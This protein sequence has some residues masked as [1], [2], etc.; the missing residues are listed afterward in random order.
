M[1]STVKH[2]RSSTASKRPTASGLA[3]GQL[4]INTAS[5]TPGLFL[6]NSAGAVVKVGPVHVGASAPNAVPAGSAGN[7]TGELW[8]NNSATIHGLNY[9]TGSA[10]VNLTP[11]GTTTVAGLVELATNAET[12]TGTDTVRAV[13]PSG[14]QS[15]VSDSTSTTS[16]T[17][18]ASSTAVKSAYDVAN[19]AL[20]K[21]GGRI[22]GNLEIGP[23]GSLSFE[24]SSDDSFETTLA[25]VNPTADRTITLPNTTGTVITTG[26]SG[27][28]TSAM[29][30][31]LNIVNADINASAAI[32]LSKLATGAL[33][34]AITVASA[35]IVNG[36]IVNADISASA[37]IAD[38]KLDTIS[39]AGK[40]SGTAITSGDIATSGDLEITSTTPIVR[41][42]ESDGTAT[43][44]QTAIVRNNDQFLLQTRSSTGVLLSNDYLIPADASGATE[45][46]WRIANTE[47]ARLDS[48][49]LTVVNDLT[50]SDKIIHAG[51]T[52][53][54]IRFPAADTVAVET[55]G[56]ERLRIKSDGE[57]YFQANNTTSAVTINQTGTG[58][59]LVVE[60]STNPDATPFVIDETGRT[61]Q[62]H[63]VALSLNGTGGTPTCQLNT[64]ASTLFAAACYS[65]VNWGDTPASPGIFLA[66][67]RAGAVG[68]YTIVPNNQNLGEIRFAGAD[69]SQFQN[70]AAIGVQVDGTPSDGIV[71]GRVV[72]E[73]AN[74]SGTLTEAMRI[75][76]TGAVLVGAT[77]A[78]TDVADG[79]IALQNRLVMNASASNYGQFQ[80]I[81]DVGT[82]ITATTGTIVFKFKSSAPTSHRSAFVK[83]NLA[84][85]ANNSTPSNSPACEYAFQLHQTSGGIC[86]ING[87]TTIFEYTFVRATHF[88][89]ADLGSGECTVTLTN[90]VAVS[91]IPAYMV[92]INTQAGTFGLDAVTIT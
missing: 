89:F 19:A 34:T 33:P 64:P 82:N 38:T 75:T 15:K 56:T 80:R 83:I 62:G 92:E 23:A 84:G 27:T 35:N 68:T 37:A 4:A 47:K 41:L 61:V 51:D 40:V 22:T 8:V 17:T 91:L 69:G 32:A 59:A 60:D 70:A 29:I 43:H 81:A 11:S 66:K 72:F 57:S 78:P 13:T 73:T 88:A 5:G 1:A 28:V 20:P 44:S 87:T 63:T 14:L 79:D 21:A 2:L 25:V 48:T 52:N 18:I 77:A 36:T 16:S 6:K 39:T 9:Y 55:D 53:T 65:A 76:S 74:S 46:Q 58:N 45:H 50:I 26:D 86:S 24:G 49:G 31:D 67:A 90:P 54:A 7:S 12:Q 85:R 30:A 10:F 3:E 42:A 71:P